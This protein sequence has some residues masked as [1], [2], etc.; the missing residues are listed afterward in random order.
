MDDLLG[1]PQAEPPAAAPAAGAAAAAAVVAWLPR[2][3]LR[4]N[5]QEPMQ[6]SWLGGGPA[7]LP[8]ARESGCGASRPQYDNLRP[9]RAR[10]CLLLPPCSRHIPPARRSGAGLCCRGAGHKLRAAQGRVP[11]LLSSQQR[12][13]RRR[14]H[15][16]ASG[17]EGGGSSGG[18]AGASRGGAASAPGAGC[19]AG[20]GSRRRQ[21]SRRQCTDQGRRSAAAV[22]V[23]WMA[24]PAA[25]HP[26]KL[27][28]TLRGDDSR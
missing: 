8:P 7:G 2:L 4:N 17:G 24:A 14:W 19:R 11:G 5:A 15:A 16:G 28:V 18:A 12:R 23:R 6:A 26:C 13:R 10:A 3:A 27:C 22:G 25:P 21:R 20:G 1:E 9:A